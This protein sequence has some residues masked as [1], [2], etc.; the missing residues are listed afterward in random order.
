[1]Q[2]QGEAAAFLWH[3]RQ[4]L[5]RTNDLFQTLA[6]LVRHVSVPWVRCRNE[7]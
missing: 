1:M 5:A 3:F 7:G 4:L 6:V 2:M